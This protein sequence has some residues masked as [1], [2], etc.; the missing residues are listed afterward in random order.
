MASTK[1]LSERLL[2]RPE[3]KPAFDEADAGRQ[4]LKGVIDSTLEERDPAGT[5]AKLEHELSYA[6]DAATAAPI[7]AKLSAYRTHADAIRRN[8]EIK[9]S[10]V[11]A[12]ALKPAVRKLLTV[13]LAGVRAEQAADVED[14]RSFYASFGLPMDANCSVIR[15]WDSLAARFSG[16]LADIDSLN[17]HIA[18]N[19]PNAGAFSSTFALFE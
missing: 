3:I 1:S 2:A 5:I 4:A 11:C 7:S 15:R 19:S 9:A 12:Q 10:T 18:L 14:V 16:L 6:A 8:A 17:V 13:G